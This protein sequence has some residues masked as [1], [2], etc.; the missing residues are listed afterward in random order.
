MVGGTV[1]IQILVN[2]HNGV[3]ALTGRQ[4]LQ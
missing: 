4:W 1:Y 3:Q 2:G